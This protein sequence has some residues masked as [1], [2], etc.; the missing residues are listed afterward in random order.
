M[1]SVTFK[2]KP[3]LKILKMISGLNQT[4]PEAL[5]QQYQL[6]DKQKTEV[7]TFLTKLNTALE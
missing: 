7:K 2:K 5:Q 3:E 1:T 4:I 6:T